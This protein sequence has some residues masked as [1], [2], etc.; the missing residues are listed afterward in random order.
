M[1]INVQA[2]CILP[3]FIYAPLFLN[4]FS[5][6]QVFYSLEGKV[7]ANKWFLPLVWASDITARAMEEGKIK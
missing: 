6:L 5:V 1:I 4:L 7:T 2:S 3:L